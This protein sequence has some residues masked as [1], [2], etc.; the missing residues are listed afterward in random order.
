MILLCVHYLL[1]CLVLC[2]FSG[3]RHNSIML[4]VYSVGPG[5]TSGRPGKFTDHGTILSSA[6][7]FLFCRSIISLC[8]KVHHLLHE[9][10]TAQINTN[11]KG[12]SPTYFSTSVPS[13][14]RRR[15]QT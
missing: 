13:S 5:E 2:Y 11:N 12:A 3:S 6:N 1:G 8:L 10:N 14:G 15:C 9:P 4:S 7:K